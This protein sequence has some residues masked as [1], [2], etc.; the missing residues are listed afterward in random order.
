VHLVG[1]NLADQPISR[2]LCPGCKLSNQ[3]ASTNRVRYYSR[4]RSGGPV[5]LALRSCVSTMLELARQNAG[6]HVLVADR[7]RGVSPATSLQVSGPRPPLAADAPTPT[8]L[9]RRPPSPHI[10][11]TIQRRSPDVVASTDAL[12]P[13]PIRKPRRFDYG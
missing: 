12:T 4:W 11:G 3:S 8:N 6:E 9:S 1:R 13:P 7:W 2:D 5:L 10:E